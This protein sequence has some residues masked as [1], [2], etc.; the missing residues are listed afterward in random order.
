MLTKKAQFSHPTYQPYIQ[1]KKLK[2]EAVSYCHVL[3]SSY[4]RKVHST[5]ANKTVQASNVEIIHPSYENIVHV[6]VFFTFL[7][8]FQVFIWALHTSE[9]RGNEIVM[10]FGARNS[11]LIR[12]S[13]INTSMLIQCLFLF[14]YLHSHFYFSNFQLVDI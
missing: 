5:S 1:Y 12:A 13:I 6:R 10:D 11:S 14:F 3:I 8:C 9:N 2:S 4:P 7:C